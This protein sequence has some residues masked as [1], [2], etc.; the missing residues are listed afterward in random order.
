M[1]FG[2]KFVHNYNGA[3]YRLH[4]PLVTYL[5][6]KFVRDEMKSSN[7][8]PSDNVLFHSPTHPHKEFHKRFSLLPCA[9]ERSDPV[10]YFHRLK[11]VES[12]K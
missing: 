4:T 5:F 6:R 12:D 7:P 2:S 10:T 8:Q 9:Y 1:R 11:K 3:Q